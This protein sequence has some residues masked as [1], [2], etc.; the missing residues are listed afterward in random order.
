MDAAPWVRGSW[1]QAVPLPGEELG[2]GPAPGAL[3]TAVCGDA[4]PPS[5]AAQAALPAAPGVRSSGSVA[6]A[7]GARP[8]C[9]WVVWVSVSARSYRL[10]Q[11]SWERPDRALLP[12]LFGWVVSDLPVY[13]KS[14]LGLACV[15]RCRTPGLRPLAELEPSAH[16]LSLD[17]RN[18]V[19]LETLN[20]WLNMIL[21]DRESGEDE[22]ALR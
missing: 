13:S 19:G 7:S 3:P 17:A 11:E 22:L 9:Q 8:R 20:L 12:P 5:T 4:R 10:L 1:R 2:V 14:T 21:V 16:P 15:L 6:S 18:G